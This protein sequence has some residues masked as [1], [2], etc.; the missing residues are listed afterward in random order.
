MG[1]IP[2]LCVAGP[3]ATGKTA[4]AIRLAKTLGGEVIGMDSMQ[5][6]RH[7]DIGTAKPTPAERQAVPH[8]LIDVAEPGAP[9]TVAQYAQLATEAARQIFAR[10]RLPVLAGGTGF[11][12]RALTEGLSLGVAQSDTALRASLRAQAQEPG[13]K[14]RLHA[15][16]AEVDPTSAARLHEN[17]V[18]RVTRALEV[19]LLTGEPISRQ[20]PTGGGGPFSFC[21]IG[22][23]TER[24]RLYQR[25]NARVDGMVLCGLLNEVRAL[26]GQGVPP[27]AQAMQ[28][29]GYKELVP[30]AM[31]GMPLDA[32]V[33]AVKQNTRHYAKRQWTW[34]R[35]EPRMQWL[36]MDS[37]D[38]VSQALHIGESF[39]KDAEQWI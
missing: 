15:R 35:A 39:W 14:G 24:A 1:K 30:V 4:L 18:Q 36:D 34:F 22:A 9:F 31:R 33:A 21:L 38:A 6:Y 8:H 25:I 20:Q 19:F 27:E 7:M 2:V 12:L 23:T 17:D 10:G 16:L 5:V 11:Y 13:G 3:T 26:L 28:G 32:A 29:I 37:P